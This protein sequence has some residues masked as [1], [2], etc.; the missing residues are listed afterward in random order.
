MTISLY[1][2]NLIAF[3]FMIF[4]AS[5]LQRNTY[6]IK[7]SFIL[8]VIV[9]IVMNRKY[10]YTLKDNLTIPKIFFNYLFAYSLYLFL[11]YVSIHINSAYNGFADQVFHSTVLNILLVILSCIVAI[12]LNVKYLKILGLIVLSVFSIEVLY[13]FIVHN[14]SLGPR[15]ATGFGGIL[16]LGQDTTFILSIIIAYFIFNKLSFIKSNYLIYPLAFIFLYSL[17][18]TGSRSPILGLLVASV[19]IYTVV[20]GKIKIKY[21]LK[22]IFYILI[23]MSILYFVNNQ[24]RLQINSLMN[25]LE[26]VSNA[27]K[28]VANIISLSM[29]IDNPFFGSGLGT[30]EGLKEVYMPSFITSSIID[31][32]DVPHNMFLGILGETGIFVFFVYLYVMLKP[33][34]IY[35]KLFNRYRDFNFSYIFLGLMGFIIVY[36]IDSLFHNYYT[37]NFIW[38]IIGFGYGLIA[39]KKLK[40]YRS[41][42]SKNK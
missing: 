42:Y 23:I 11:L 28:L 16:Q 29:F 24:V 38:I 26:D 13:V 14:P 35:K 15:R 31:T 22:I 19:F 3:A 32:V 7:G 41:E 30:F 37:Q 9:T 21:I 10:I 18:A 1:R 20:K 6:L 39:N 27:S 4:G 40:E 34:F 12:N 36:N 17:Y 25:P 33:I 8:L 5:M 2:L